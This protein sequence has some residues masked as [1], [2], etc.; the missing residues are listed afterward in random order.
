MQQGR[1]AFRKISKAGGQAIS[2]A[3]AEERMFDKLEDPTFLADVRP[4]L[5]ADEAEKFDKK[6]ERAA[7]IAVFKTFIKLLPGHAWAQTPEMAN[8]HDMPELAKD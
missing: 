8:K 7:F 6:A 4:L 2:R 3:E 5:S 1:D